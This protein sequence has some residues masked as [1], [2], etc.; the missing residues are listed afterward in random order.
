MWKIGEV[1]QN[2]QGSRGQRKSIGNPGLRSMEALCPVLIA[3]DRWQGRL[4]HLQQCDGQHSAEEAGH[5]Q[6]ENE[7]LEAEPESGRSS[8]LGVAPAHPACRKEAEEH[9]QH[10]GARRT[11]HSEDLPGHANRNG[12]NDEASGQKHADPV[13]N[14]HP[15][16]VGRCRVGSQGRENNQAGDKGHERRNGHERFS[17]GLPER[18]SV[19]STTSMNARG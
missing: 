8:E 19:I 4:P 13:G 3:D 14:R 2:K 17:R 1:R 18:I 11:M 12:E 9:D 7:W 10:Q 5:G 15:E 6:I 16:Q